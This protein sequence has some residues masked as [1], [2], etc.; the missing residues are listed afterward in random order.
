LYRIHTDN[1]QPYY[2]LRFPCTFGHTCNTFIKREQTATVTNMGNMEGENMQIVTSDV[3]IVADIRLAIV[4][5][6]C[7][8][9]TN[10][11]RVQ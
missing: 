5:W 11:F 10:L 8:D 6:K 1:T 7:N 2:L 3:T 4:A 9:A